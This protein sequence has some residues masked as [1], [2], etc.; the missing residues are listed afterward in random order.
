MIKYLNDEVTRE[1]VGRIASQFK[2]NLSLFRNLVSRADF[3]GDVLIELL[4]ACKPYGGIATLTQLINYVISLVEFVVD[5]DG[6]I[7]S[8]AVSV[9]V[10]DISVTLIGW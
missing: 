2:E 5:I 9:D 4:V 10:F 8:R 3:D 6:M 7:P 1:A